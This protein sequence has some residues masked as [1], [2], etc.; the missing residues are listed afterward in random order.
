MSENSAYSNSGQHNPRAEDRVQGN[1]LNRQSQVENKGIS[2]KTTS[3]GARD[4]NKD[5]H[6]IETS[7]SDASSAKGKNVVDHMHNGGL[8]KPNDRLKKV[9]VE[10]NPEDEKNE[11]AQRKKRKRT[12]MND[13]QVSLIE[14]A[15]LDEPDMHRNAALL[16]S[17]ADKLS[18]HVCYM[19]LSS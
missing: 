17:W 11:F 9:A 15:L 5:A 12:I 10:E 4:T 1:G 2:G 14:R 7:G 16:Q 19:Q 6:K 3:G 8:S 18:T 13:N